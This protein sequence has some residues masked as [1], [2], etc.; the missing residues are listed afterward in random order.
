M[1]LLFEQFISD[2]KLKKCKDELLAVLQGY[3]GRI[4]GVRGADAALKHSYD[5]LIAR[6]SENRGGALWYPYLA[7]GM[8]NGALV[9][10]ADGSV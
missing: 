4:T 3:Q 6:F 9:E 2:P 10:L 7:S 5:A 8:G 1:P